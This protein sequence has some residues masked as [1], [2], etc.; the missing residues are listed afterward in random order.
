MMP[1]QTIL[2]NLLLAG[3]LLTLLAACGATDGDLTPPDVTFDGAVV[4][5]TSRPL[6]IPDRLEPTDIVALKGDKSADATIDVEINTAA[7]VSN[8]VQTDNAWSCEVTGLIEG[9]NT[10]YLTATDP[11]GNN[12]QLQISIIV[13]L[14]GP[15]VTIDQYS[16]PS[17]A[18][19]QVLAGTV[20][21]LDSDVEVSTD[22]GASWSL[23]DGVDANLWWYTFTGT[24][25]SIYDV[26]VR[27]I[28]RLGNV[29]AAENYAVLP[30]L[31]VD[32]TAPV[33]TV[34]Q[35]LPFVLPDPLLDPTVALSGL[36]TSGATLVVTNAPASP[37]ILDVS[38]SMTEWTL[39]YS[40]LPSGNTVATF[41]VDDAGNVAQAK[42]LL[43]RDT[44]AP[45][46]IDVSRDINVGDP[47]VVW[48]GEEMDANIHPSNLV[49]L[50]SLGTAITVDSAVYDMP[51]RSFSFASAALET[52]MVYTATLQSLVSPDTLLDQRG[53][54]VALFS[55]KVRVR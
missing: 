46:V 16:T 50:D 3:V 42:V 21:E 1:M 9:T 44:T 24:D 28:D 29:T 31:K 33:F 5:P 8:L 19:T 20:A 25:G 2:K 10:I 17:S 4:L 18:T 15:K 26:Q 49:L 35:T 6:T 23:A 41:T 14:T 30:E 54:A 7:S 45:A 11:V 55:W 12:R 47:I 34:N 52:G 48:F 43:W 53:N 40:N 51:T 27:G 36:R 13:D 38:S 37:Y 32:S 22:G 39:N